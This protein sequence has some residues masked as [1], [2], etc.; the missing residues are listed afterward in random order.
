MGADYFREPDP[1]RVLAEYPIGAA[2]MQGPARLH[3]D[4]LW[5]LQEQ[6]FAALMRRGLETCSYRKLRPNVLM[7][8]PKAGRRH[9]QEINGGNGRPGRLRPANGRSQVVWTRLPCAHPKICRVRS[10]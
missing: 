6:R 5:A 10:R 8:Q 9:H 7:I 4:A 3:A 1:A 2:V